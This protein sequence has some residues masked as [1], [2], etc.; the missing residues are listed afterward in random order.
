MY[1]PEHIVE[2][3]NMIWIGWVIV[4]ALSSSISISTI[5]GHSDMEENQRAKERPDQL[6][7][8]ILTDGA[9]GTSMPFCATCG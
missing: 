9:T 6:L 7:R 2:W 3:K 8:K 1:A 4:V 5:P